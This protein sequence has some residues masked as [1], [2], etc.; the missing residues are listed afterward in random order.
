MKGGESVTV[1]CSNNTSFHGCVFSGGEM[2]AQLPCAFAFARGYVRARVCVRV[3]MH[4]CIKCHK[5]GD[6]AE[7]RPP[8]LWP[9]LARHPLTC[10][11]LGRTPNGIAYTAAFARS[12]LNMLV[13]ASEGNVSPDLA[14]HD[15]QFVGSTGGDETA[16][17]VGITVY[18][19]FKV[20]MNNVSIKRT[21]TTA[22]WLNHNLAT[23]LCVS[24]V[25]RTAKTTGAVW[26]AQPSRFS[27]W[28]AQ[29]SLI[30]TGNGHTHGACF[31]SRHTVSI[32][33]FDLARWV[34]QGHLRGCAAIYDDTD[35]DSTIQHCSVTMAA[36][37]PD[38]WGII[39]DAPSGQCPR[40]FKFAI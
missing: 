30:Q 25:W 22:L 27:I 13:A 19:G 35:G 40:Q 34:P 6:R 24:I 9:S 39:L 2:A 17:D 32:Q 23:H 1:Y 3:C 37:D 5:K 20:T 8:C 12:G 21:R 38:A 15:S 29:V 28:H 4:V 36:D 11:A 31:L 26:N 18:A 14:V 7:G 33:E 10:H 16:P